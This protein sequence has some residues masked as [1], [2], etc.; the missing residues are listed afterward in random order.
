MHDACE[1]FKQNVARLTFLVESRHVGKYQEI[2]FEREARPGQAGESFASQS[3]VHTQIYF[4]K[5]LVSVKSFFT[6]ALTCEPSLAR[7]Q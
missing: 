6:R 5:F 7:S 1:A 4:A 2:C 3:F